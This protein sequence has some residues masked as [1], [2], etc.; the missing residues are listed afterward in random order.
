MNI[1]WKQDKDEPDWLIAD[2]GPN[3]YYVSPDPDGNGYWASFLAPCNHFQILGWGPVQEYAKGLVE[4]WLDYVN[5][6]EIK[7]ATANGTT[8]QQS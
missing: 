2:R 4:L 3:R 8:P 1:D 6:Q 5:A 7:E